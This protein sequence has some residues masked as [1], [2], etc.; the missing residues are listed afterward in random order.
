MKISA[1]QEY[2]ELAEFH[3]TNHERLL[4]KYAGALMAESR[5]EIGPQWRAHG[6]GVP[7]ARGHGGL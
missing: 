5:Q 6:D 7:R 3:L 1:R 2:S 4:E